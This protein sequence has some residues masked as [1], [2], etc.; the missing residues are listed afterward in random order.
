MSQKLFCD[1]CGK[2]IV[3][4]STWLF[5]RVYY[6]ER[7]LISSLFIDNSQEDSKQLCRQCEDSYV[8]WFMH[9]EEDEG[10]G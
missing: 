8:H 6:S 4:G 3:G 5:G 7:R 2:E 1:R 9:P 10:N